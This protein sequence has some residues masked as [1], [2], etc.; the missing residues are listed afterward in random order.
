ML[1]TVSITESLRGAGGNQAIFSLDSANLRQNRGEL[2]RAMSLVG[3]TLGEEGLNDYLEFLE[4]SGKNESMEKSLQVDRFASFLGRYQNLLPEEKLAS[5]VNEVS[6]AYPLT[7]HLD[8]FLL[9][10]LAFDVCFVSPHLRDVGLREY[11]KNHPYRR[12]EVDLLFSIGAQKV[13]A[14]VK[15]SGLRGKKQHKRLRNLARKHEAWLIYV[16]GKASQNPDERDFVDLQ[17][18]HEILS[19]SDPAH[20]LSELREFNVGGG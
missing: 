2:L 17:T 6:Q 4:W 18:L 12:Q 3:H 1:R 11:F 8:G 15:M 5:V 7:D 20:V 13:F 16:G 19:Y 10:L 9:E 14:E